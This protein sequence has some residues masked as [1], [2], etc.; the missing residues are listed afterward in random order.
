MKEFYDVILSSALFGGIKETELEAMLCC[1]DAKKTAFSKDS[2]LQRE[3]EK[4]TSV[5]LI[6]QG[7]ALT[8]KEDV[9]GNRN[10]IS[11]LEPGQTFSAA[12]ACAAAL[13][14]AS[15]IAETT[16]YVLRLDV[17]K[18]MTVCSSA[19]EHHSRVIRN[20]VAELALKNLQTNEKLTHM[21]QRTTKSKLMSYFSALSQR[22]GSYEFDIPFTR[23]QLADYLAVDRS[24]LTVELGKMQKD[25]LIIIEKNHVIL[26]I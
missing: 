6:L 25:G 17:R 18:I 14:T 22:Q 21:G 11:R 5:G 8:I 2:F 15:V 9:W 10:I 3:G 23:Q 26:K 13:T 20:L 4:T 12:S 7:S 24:G 19:C 16:G 1:L